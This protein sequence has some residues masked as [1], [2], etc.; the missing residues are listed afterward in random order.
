[1]PFITKET[2]SHALADLKGTAD[3][4]LKIWFTLK[5]MGM[6]NDTSVIID[7]SSPHTDLQRLF[8]FGSP[9]GEFYVP[10]AHTERF[11]TMK[12]DADRS[13]IQTNLTRW[14]VSDSVVTVNPNAYLDILQRDDKTLL[15]SQG[16][17]YPFGLGHGKNGFSLEDDSRVS[18][19]LISFGFWYYRQQEF[20]DTQN[21]LDYFQQALR[22][23]LKITVPEQELIFIQDEPSWRPSFQKRP[24]LDEQIYQVVREFLNS[25]SADRKYAVSESY[26]EYSVKVNSMATLTEGPKWLNYDP[27]HRM[28]SLIKDGGKAI[29]LYGPPRSGK[30]RAVD[31]VYPRDNP[32]RETI[33]IHSGWGYDEL[34]L[35]LRPG[36]D[37][38][39]SY[40]EGPFLTAIKSSKKCI[41]L[42]EINRTEFSQAIG[43]V[44]SLIENAYRG[45][46]FGIRLRNGD[47]F[48]IPETILIVCTMNT[49]D[50]ST[51]ELDDAILGRMDAIEFPPRVEDLQEMLTSMGFQ[52][53]VSRNI[54][55]FFAFVQ[56]YYPLGHGYFA[57]LKPES[58]FVSFYLSKIRPVLQK[59][60]KD[61]RDQEL[62]AIDQKV[63][64]LFGK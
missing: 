19:P 55:L 60:L 64:E 53:E 39:W 21:L 29:L 45:E 34:I 44:F 5:Q 26:Q 40:K 17:N 31:I 1:M 36:K 24:L 59:H 47:A 25:S 35:G 58:N 14:A 13:I 22:R 12:H 30:T 56:Q 61:Y 57:G 52:E 48:F 10:F 2:L 37:G 50:R 42:E 49:L 54:R 18:I 7:T 62:A 32:D 6:D 11:M 38:S 63:D 8:G 41:V 33:Q 4:M 46:K 27:L 15:V 28:E 51:E 3:H 23:D 9:E 20:I 43:E 16:R